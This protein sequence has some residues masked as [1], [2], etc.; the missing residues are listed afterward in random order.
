M[1][2]KEQIKTEVVNYLQ[3]A[4]KHLFTINDVEHKVLLEGDF[5]II[6]TGNSISINS[7]SNKID[8]YGSNSKCVIKNDIFLVP[9]YYN[10]KIK[11]INNYKLAKKKYDEISE[12]ITSKTDKSIIHG[13][14]KLI[15]DSYKK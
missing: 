10:K 4:S 9:R 1:K 11:T 7:I 2:T 5:Y 13:S 3:K 15:L 6:I 14:C 12:S 8:Y